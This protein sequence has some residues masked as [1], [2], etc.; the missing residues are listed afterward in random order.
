MRQ[1]ART[2][3]IFV[4]VL[5]SLFL[6]A[7]IFLDQAH[8]N[9]HYMEELGIITLNEKIKA[10]AFKLRDLNG[11]EVELEDFRGKI[12]F[13]NF[14]ATWCPP[15]RAE[16]PS[17]EELYAKFKNEDF[18]IL[19]VD[20]QES[21]EKV[22]AFKEQYQLSFP[23]LLDS[24]GVVGLFYGVRSIPTT[25]LVDKESFI[26]GGALGAR[27]WASPEAFGLIEQLLNHSPPS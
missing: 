11:M 22:T 15:C 13:L 21:S 5:G 18:T 12:V 27:N 20:L 14:W 9:V 24:D 1:R 7:H 3:S 26:I 19:A 10:P 2:L 16:M 17:M 6:N 25:Y 8:G 23:I 4:T